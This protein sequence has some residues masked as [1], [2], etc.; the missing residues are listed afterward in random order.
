MNLRQH[1]D[2]P[3]NPKPILSIGAGAIVRNA[4]YPA[5][6]MANFPVAGVYDV[7]KEVAENLAREFN[8]PYAAPSLE[9]LIALATKDT[10]F[11]LAV[12]GNQVA[13]TLERLPDHAYALIQKPMGE[14]LEQAQEILEVVER[15]GLRAA[16]NFQLRWAPYSLA[17]QDLIA[18][19]ALGEVHEL[20]FK[21]CV[22]T[23][24]HLWDFLEKAPRMEMVYHS[25]H[26]FDLA[27]HLFGEPRSVKAHSIKDP[28]YPNLESSRST[29]ILDYG[30]WKRAT[31]QTYHGHRAGPK[32]QESY[33]RVEGDK[34]AA[35][36]QMGLNLNY[37]EGGQ[38]VFEYWTE[39][40]GEWTTVPLEGSWFPHAFR[41]PMSAMMAW[42]QN[43]PPPWTEVHDAFKTM[44]L[45]EAAYRDSDKSAW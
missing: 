27:R 2:L 1:P 15:K 38:D 3:A 18:Q 41:G 6:R 10:I 42:T 21:V 17:L 40:T 25:I 23:P 13:E 34:G 29:A 9:D 8:I 31:I 5:Y 26:Y 14:T 45:V 44:E 33:I 22:Y 43:A 30:D 12:P 36:I 19:G 7:R 39:Q 28:R 16:V 20:E 11:D 24:W 35:W 4:H 37:P 32:H